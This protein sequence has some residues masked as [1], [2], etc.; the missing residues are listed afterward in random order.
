[1]T[2][3]IGGENWDLGK[4]K[5]ITCRVDAA[6]AASGERILE[7]ASI[8]T[9]QLVARLKSSPE[10]SP[11]ISPDDNLVTKVAV[12][13]TSTNGERVFVVHDNGITSGSR[14]EPGDDF[15]FDGVE[16]PIHGPTAPTGNSVE[17][18]CAEGTEVF[19]AGSAV[20]T[21]VFVLN[22]D[23]QMHQSA[24]SGPS[25]SGATIVLVSFGP[26]MSWDAMDSE[27]VMN[28]RP[29]SPSLKALT[30]TLHEPLAASELSGVHDDWLALFPSSG[31]PLEVGGVAS[32]GEEGSSVATRDIDVSP[33]DTGLLQAALAVNNA[34][35]R[36]PAA[37]IE[38]IP[39][40]QPQD[41]LTA[42]EYAPTEVGEQPENGQS[43]R[44]QLP[45]EVLSEGVTARDNKPPTAVQSDSE[46]TS[47]AVI[48]GDAVD[49]VLTAITAGLLITRRNRRALVRL[50]RI[51]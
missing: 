7:F 11:Q 29:L 1:L 31:A 28:A 51:S 19:E 44:G 39:E 9:G 27:A 40:E 12:V 18:D 23:G 37:H 20:S 45:S 13:E 32:A 47:A 35:W 3:Q 50:S 16:I 4:L 26:T 30:S 2:I 36:E 42:T 46:E 6:S 5:W 22:A 14:G 38:T 25:D 48:S 49:L 8:E 34:S 17:S 15:Q 21:H 33:R 24:H 10:V 43:S 41:L